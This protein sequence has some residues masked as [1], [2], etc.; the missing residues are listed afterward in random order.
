MLPELSPFIQ[1]DCLLRL[2]NQTRPLLSVRSSAAR[3]DVLHDRR[4][5]PLRVESHVVQRRLGQYPH[6]ASPARM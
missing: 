4:D 5:E 3:L 1:N 6:H 2:Q